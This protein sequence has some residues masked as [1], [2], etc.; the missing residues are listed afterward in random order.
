M[1]QFSEHLTRSGATIKDSKRNTWVTKDNFQNM[2]ENVYKEM[3]KAGV[4]EEKEENIE[5][6]TGLPSRF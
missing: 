3:V 2:Y 4:A 6:E 1:S 5:Y